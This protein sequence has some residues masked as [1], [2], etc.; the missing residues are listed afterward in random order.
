[1][2]DKVIV[3]EAGM[4]QCDIDRTPSALFTD[5]EHQRYT[6]LCRHSGR[7][8]IKNHRNGSV[9]DP[10]T[11]SPPRYSTLV[12]D[13]SGD[14]WLTN[15]ERLFETLRIQQLR[16][17]KFFHVDP[18]HRDALL[19]FAVTSGRTGE[20]AEVNGCVGR[21]RSKH[22][23]KKERAAKRQDY[24][25][26]S[27][28]LFVDQCRGIVDHYC[29]RDGMIRKEVV[30]D[31]DYHVGDGVGEGL[32]TV[33]TNR[34]MHQARIVVIAVGPG[35]SP[36]IPGQ[37]PGQRIDGACHVMQMEKFPDPVVKTKITR[38]QT[39]NVLVVGGGL[40]S[41]QI[42]D[43]EIK[44]G[45]TK[46]W[47][48]MRSHLKVKPFDLNL[49]WL[50]K[51]RN[52][53]QAIFWSADSDEERWEQ[54]KLA[55]NG[56]SITPTFHKIMKAHVARGR[57]SVFTNTVVEARVWDPGA[58]RWTV[59]TEPEIDLPPLD[60]IY[61]ATGIQSDIRSLPFLQT[62]QKKFP[63]E[64][65]GGLPCIND[66]LMWKDEVPLFVTGRLG[67]LKIGPGAANLAGARSGAERIAWSIADILDENDVN[68]VDKDLSSLGIG[69]RYNSLTSDSETDPDESQESA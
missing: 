14:E 16:N 10:K 39:T 18:A 59:Q 44:S 48:V 15:W 46:V 38:G 17:P 35:N 33:K 20:C 64:S 9:R 65:H 55:R 8:A 63:I 69:N 52:V 23:R 40:T 34:G 27:S 11:S 22:A 5:D 67:A 30:E 41:A 54:I 61:Y 25:T 60:Y 66:D 43:L 2:A 19:E 45:V 1:M 47:H 36:R 53:K 56:G 24:Y 62:I 26:P 58:Q 31:L 13:A 29:L 7:M 32:F 4:D 6:W 68:L 21:E 37:I 12:L 50:G 42:G 3:V 57:L 51:F 49:E 28:G